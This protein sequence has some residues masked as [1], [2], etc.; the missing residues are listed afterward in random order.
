MLKP[1][2][3]RSKRL[4]LVLWIFTAFQLVAS[5]S[6]FFQYLLLKRIEVG[7]FNIAETDSNDIRQSIVSIL[8]MLLLVGTGIVFIQWFRRAY[9]NLHQLSTNLTHS[10]GWAAGAW[11]VPIMNLGRPYNIMKEMMSVAQ[12]LL[13]RANIVQEDPRRKRSVGIWW[14]LWIIITILGDANARIQ[15]KSEN[16]TVLIYTTI[17]SIGIA[18]AY[19]PLTIFTVKMIKYYAELEVYLPQITANNKQEIK[20]DDSDILDSI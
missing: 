10:E 2:K 4:I 15:T 5:I 6:D 14:A 20:I 19:I 9:Y 12:D 1:N 16:L 7:N 18:I 3:E 17:A 8:V 13:I 11:F